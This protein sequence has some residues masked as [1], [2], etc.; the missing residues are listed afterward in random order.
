MN[1]FLASHSRATPHAVEAVVLSRRQL[2]VIA[3]L[4]CIP[5]PLFSYA[6]TVVPLPEILERAAADF[7]P[8]IS[9]ST[10]GSGELVREEAAPPHAVEILYRPSERSATDASWP[11]VTRRATARTLHP[12]FRARGE[13]TA[14]STRPITAAPARSGTAG[15]VD[16]GPAPA[17]STPDEP[18][19]PGT[20]AS[21]GEE[22]GGGGA[23][24]DIPVGGSDPGASDPAQSPGSSPPTTGGSDGSGGTA[25]EEAPGNS[26]DAPG[27]G[28]EGGASPGGPPESGGGQGGGSPPAE[29]PATQGSPPDGKS[30]RP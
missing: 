7:V 19:N 9:P 12:P 13:H 23:G 27:H 15:G 28:G 30:G 4:T 10:G 21:G 11:A 8:F 22:V 26:A 1:E 5:I 2:L 14:G 25:G 16:G 6:A 20:G 17:P 3:L 18:D 29:P 24:I